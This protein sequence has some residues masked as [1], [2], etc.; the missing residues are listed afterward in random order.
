LSALQVG[1]IVPL[2]ATLE[3]PEGETVFVRATVKDKDNLILI[4]IPL[5]DNGGGEFSNFSYF[6]PDEPLIKIRYETFEDPSFTTPAEFCP[7][8]ES[9]SRLEI[10][11]AQAVT[12]DSLIGFVKSVKL[13]GKINKNEK[14]L[15]GLI[16]KVNILE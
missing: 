3:C 7:D 6:M 13:F 9:Y 4:Q 11:K 14:G 12:T 10:S 1:Q 5:T 15:I 16:N 2:L 8:D